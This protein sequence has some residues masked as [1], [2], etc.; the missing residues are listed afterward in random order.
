MTSVLLRLGGTA[1]PIHGIRLLAVLQVQG[2]AVPA[3]SYGGS[4]AARKPGHQDGGTRHTE[5]QWS[6]LGGRD[7]N[8]PA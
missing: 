6:V 4:H 3:R 1:Y 8:G 2:Q 5:R 7:V